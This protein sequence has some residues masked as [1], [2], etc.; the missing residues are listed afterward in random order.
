MLL[1][2]H[3]KN[4]MRKKRETFLINGKTCISCMDCKK[5]KP[6]EEFGK[7]GGTWFQAYCKPCASLRNKIYQAKYYAQVKK[8]SVRV[9]PPGTPELELFIKIMFKELA[10]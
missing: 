9:V 10:L 6:V 3:I 1:R 8:N 2:N 5:I 7:N 4:T